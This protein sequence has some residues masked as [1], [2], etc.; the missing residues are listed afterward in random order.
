MILF[1]VVVLALVLLVMGRIRRAHRRADTSDGL[2]QALG[3]NQ[4]KGPRW[5]VGDRWL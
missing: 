3:Q 5:K 1:V 4:Y 2:L